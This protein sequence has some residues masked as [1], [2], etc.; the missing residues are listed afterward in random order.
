MKK[1]V[2]FLLSLFIFRCVLGLV[3]TKDFV[4]GRK[5]RVTGYPINIHR[6]ITNCI[7]KID[8]F[9]FSVEDNCAKFYNSKLT[10]VGSLNKT[11]IDGINGDLWLRD[12]KL[13]VL[14]KAVVTTEL[15]SVGKGSL[16]YFREFL[17]SRF[18]KFVPDPESGLLSGIVLGYKNDIGRK[19]YEEMIGSGTVHI[20]VA[21]GY[22]ILL[23]GSTVLSMSFWF[24]RR[25]QAI[26][27]AI[28]FM[29]FY[30]LLS[31]GDPPVVRAVWMAS[32]LYIGQAI[33]RGNISYWILILTAWVMI[34]IEPSLI[35]S[36]SFQLSVAASYGLLTVDP[37]LSSRIKKSYGSSLADF[38]GKTSVLT[39]FSTM[40]VT[41]P[42]IWWHF[43]RMSVI[44]ILSNSL[45]LPFVPIV[46]M[47]GVGALVL[48]WV[49][50]VPAYVFA[51]WIVSIIRFFG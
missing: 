44:G 2:I 17:V 8:R 45:I 37:W 49:F 41:M 36:A 40:I 32:F 11:L 28:L 46:M 18:R 6:D 27:A 51:H 13:E 23:V 48:P 14:D 3:S 24:W 30:A 15:R 5:I 21:S 43:G 31:G 50:A 29:I 38:L 12:A 39:T 34:M 26:Y 7:A 22:N 9:I 20:V 33:G 19:F 10:V 1:R 25:S 16:T 4:P 42:I 35:T 47:L